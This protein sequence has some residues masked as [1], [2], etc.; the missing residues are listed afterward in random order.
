MQIIAS[1]RKAN[2]NFEIYNKFQAG[3]ILT[4]PEVK[5]LRLNSSSLNESYIEERGGELWLTNCHIKRY[6]SANNKEN[7]TTRNRKLL[8]KKKEIS[9]VIGSLKKDGFSLVPI[10]LFFNEN[11]LAKLT[12]G[13]GKGKKLHDKRES[14]KLKEW[15]RKKQRILKKN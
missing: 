2:Y 13:L 4:G 1:N 10:N 15:N 8:L 6:S 14:K 9:K 5:S 7:S 3:I 12:F 11:G